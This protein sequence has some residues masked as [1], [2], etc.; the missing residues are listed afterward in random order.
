MRS[1]LLILACLTGLATTPVQAQATG[2]TVGGL[3]GGVAGLV[4]G[5][6]FGGAITSNDCDPGNPDQCLGEAMPGFVWGAG[7]GMTVAIPVGAHIGS[8]RNGDL[9]RSLLVSGALFLAEALV[10]S[11][12][13]DDGRTEH[14]GAVQAIAIGVPVIQLV[15]S[16]W[17]ETR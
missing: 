3:L 7:I 6:L 12:L 1:A 14:M 5:G 2:A 15:T 8:G 9:G 13:S 17:S 4:G 16:V 11:Q 10:L